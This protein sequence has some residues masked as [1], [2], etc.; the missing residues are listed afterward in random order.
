[1]QHDQNRGDGNPNAQEDAARMLKNAQE[2]AARMLKNAQEDAAR[3]LKNAHH[4]DSVVFQPQIP[5]GKMGLKKD[6]IY[7]VGEMSSKL[8]HD[9]QNPLAIIKNTFEVL[10][11]KRAKLDKKT[12]ENYDRIERSVENMTQQIRDVLNY[13]KTSESQP[14]RF[15]LAPLLRTIVGY[16]DV[17]KSIRVILPTDTIITADPAQME[18]VFAN[19]LQNSIQAIEGRGTI[20]IQVMQDDKTTTIE[21]TDTGHGID[22]ENISHIFEPLFTTKQ[23]GTGLGLAS[24][25]SIIENHKGTI[26]CSSTVGKGTTFTIRLPTL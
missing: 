20:T 16:L 18:I 19:L 6:K 23:K 4:Y 10:K 25:K 12:Q 14:E 11:L 1:M 5:N 22:K 26:Q 7:T 13:V 9:L 24:C 17:P 2:D 8:V 21:V 15:H 3:M